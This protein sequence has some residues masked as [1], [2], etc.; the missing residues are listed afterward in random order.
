MVAQV[1]IDSFR[2]S[3]ITYTEYSEKL[4]A[5]ETAQKINN[6]LLEENKKN[7]TLIFELHQQILNK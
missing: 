5:I 3:S 7:Q 1:L 4:G 6:Q 2:F